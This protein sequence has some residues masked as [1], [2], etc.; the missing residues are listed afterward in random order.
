MKRASGYR[1]AAR[2]L[3]SLACLVVGLWCSG[4]VPATEPGFGRMAT[5]SAPMVALVGATLIDG[6]GGAPIADSVILIDGARITKV[7]RR[8][9][10]TIP[11][12]AT[13]VDVSKHW[14]IPGLVDAHV[15]F[16][17]TGRIYTKPGVLDL[18]RLVRY[19]DEVLW[20]KERIPETLTR[21]LCAGVTSA[22]S[23]GGPRFESEVRKAARALGRAPNVYVAY[24]PISSARLGHDIFPLVDG[25]E[26]TRYAPSAE[27]AKDRVAEARAA[28][29]DLVKVG[30]LG[31]A[32]AEEERHFFEMLPTIV[33]SAHAAGLPVAMHATELDIARKS[34]RAGVDI[35]AHTMVD[36]PADSQFVRLAVARHT[37]V[38]STLAYWGRD[39]EARTGR[40]SLL[41]IEQRC[42]DPEVIAS[43]SAV[44][45]LPA[46]AAAERLEAAHAQRIAM[47]NLKRL[48]DAGVAIAVGSDAGNFGLLHGASMH[49]EM[50]L[51]AQAGMPPADI[52][53]A[54]T[55]NAARV[56]GADDDVG[57]IEAGRLAD[58]VVLDK[59]PLVGI[60]NVAAISRVM[61]SGV[62]FN[63]DALRRPVV[64]AARASGSAQKL[65]RP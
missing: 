53:V 41:P 3:A 48:F 51:M 7:G 21:Y 35:L 64:D 28:S 29:V 32:F 49:E 61:K 47:K 63:A 20:M 24:G 46:V 10:V 37:I 31:G 5:F 2:Q 38:I 9:S 56:A 65:L 55:R 33:E 52:I 13:R 14:V 30:Y 4:D 45:P 12:E 62:L 26:S 22:V 44:Q 6:N 15:H 42:G 57:T 19:E 39:I 1:G 17:E 54:A 59:D 43:W 40:V 27:A 50:A 23:M 58:L 11:E 34:I 16:F 8:G 36:R 60:G 18:T 25:D